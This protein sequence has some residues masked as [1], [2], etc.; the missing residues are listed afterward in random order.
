MTIYKSVIKKI[1]N[2]LENRDE[3]MARLNLNPDMYH[4]Y[5][6]GRMLPIMEALSKA[7]KIEIGG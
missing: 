4:A 7:D 1:L 2:E 3:V 6:L 5:M